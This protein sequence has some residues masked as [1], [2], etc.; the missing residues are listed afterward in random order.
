[1]ARSKREGESEIF[2]EGETW[3]HL[4]GVDRD[5]GDDCAAS[6]RRGRRLRLSIFMALVSNIFSLVQ[7]MSWSLLHS[8]SEI[9]KYNEFFRDVETFT[10]MDF[11]EAES[12]SCELPEF[13]SL[14]FRDVT[15]CL[16]GD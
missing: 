14:E 1:M 15:F 8:V 5:R 2:C 9:A 16:S 11:R 4:L 3:Q 6:W 7:L 12:V 10:K 13:S